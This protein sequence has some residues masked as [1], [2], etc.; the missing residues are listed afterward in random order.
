MKVRV[1]LE[2]VIPD[3]KLHSGDQTALDLPSRRKAI[4]TNRNPFE[5]SIS[6]A[7]MRFPIVVVEDEE[8]TQR[9]DHQMY[10]CGWTDKTSKKGN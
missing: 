2:I 9:E 10:P 8:G 5:A 7:K 4:K 1:V 3:D 6:M